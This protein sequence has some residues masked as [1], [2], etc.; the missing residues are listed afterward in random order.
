MAY[1][2][3]GARKQ[4]RLLLDA[5]TIANDHVVERIIRGFIENTGDS[6]PDA[7]DNVKLAGILREAVRA[8]RKGEATEVIFR[9]HVSLVQCYC[10]R[11][12][13]DDVELPDVLDGVV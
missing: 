8:R 10:C 2:T 1:T 13:P 4:L 11:G 3:Y 5:R 9:Q 6:D 7:P 12:A